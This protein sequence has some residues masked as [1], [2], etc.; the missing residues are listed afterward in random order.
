VS[1]AHPASRANRNNLMVLACRV[2]LGAFA[3]SCGALGANVAT[4]V[5]AADASCGQCHAKILHSY[6][7]TPMANASGIAAER[8]KTGVYEHK[9]SG[10][11]Y[12]LSLQSSQLM[13]TY[14]DQKDPEIAA[15]RKLEYF[16]GSGHLGLTYLYSLNGY[17]FESPVA[18]YSASQSL[19]MKPGLESMTQAPPAL[20]VQAEC[21]RCHMSAVQHSDSGTINRYS[22]LPFLHAG[23]TCESCHGDSRQHLVTGGKAALVNPSKLS[24]TLR[25]SVCISCHLEG[26]ISVERA[27]HSALDFKAGDPIS[28]YLAYFV[29]S[30]Q[31]A[32]K[33]G[34]S[35][36]EQLSL[37]MCKRTSGD[38]MSCMS[39]H[40]PHYTPGLQERA[41]FYRKKCLACHTG[42]AF[43]IAHHA[44][45]PD[46]TSCHMKRTGAENI[47][48]VAWTDHR[49]LK[50][51]ETLNAE[52][53][54]AGDTLVP[55]FSPGTA[56]RD[57]A[58][59]YYNGLLQ[60]N[61]ALQQK[62]YESLEAIKPELSADKD[63]LAALGILS[64]ER[65]DSNQAQELFQEVL[66]L[67][68]RNLIAISNLGTLLAKSGDLQGAISL[69]RP[70]FERNEDVAGLA[71]NLAQVEC[72]A[73]DTAAARATL[74]KTLQYSPGLR[75]VRQML[76]RLPDCATPRK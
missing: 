69:W 59:A 17:L 29:Y 68:P 1:C 49:I 43:A 53:P 45:N 21:L 71:K 25:D 58:L 2:A 47:P 5:G 62:A 35:E 60:G 44:E 18:Y 42:A 38:A 24:A 6:L 19:D 26:D 75:D 52:N 33:R 57:L 65:G 14:Q 63:A 30:G 70:A 64:G 7:E 31:G 23:I 12:S 67:D 4:P 37:S 20:P 13:L 10:V 36:V 76:T 11:R 8:L 34:V 55:I 48:H 73:G 32:T 15:S 50:H 51:P 28:D 66:R 46:C 74:Q 41:S 40:D 22:G 3:L 61:F 16:L 56:K 27:G 54:G 9:L 39:C 72:I